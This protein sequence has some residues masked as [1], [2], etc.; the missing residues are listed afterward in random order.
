MIENE[1][2]NVLSCF[3]SV[4]QEKQSHLFNTLKAVEMATLEKNLLSTKIEVNNT[5]K[6]NEDNSL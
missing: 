6:Y 2:S 1:E 5:Q 3:S 4:L